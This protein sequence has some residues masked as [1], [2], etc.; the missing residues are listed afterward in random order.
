MVAVD[1]LR[2][3]C[4]PLHALLPYRRRLWL[5]RCILTVPRA[6]VAI[7]EQALTMLAFR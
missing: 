1:L 7:D 5:H 2:L 4:P 3:F 6:L